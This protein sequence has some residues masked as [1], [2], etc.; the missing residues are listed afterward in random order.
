MPWPDHGT[1]HNDEVSDAA[2]DEA[3]ATHQ[4]IA[5]SRR[6]GETV[7]EP[8]WPILLAVAASIALQ[9][10]LPNRHVLSP[11]FLFPAV[12]VL[13][14]LALLIANPARVGRRSAVRRR[15][16]LALVIVMTVDNLGAVVE[17]VRDILNDAKDDTGTVLLATGGAVWLT[18]VIA[19]SLWYWLLDRGGPAAR[20]DGT[21]SSP[22]FAFSEM[23][24]PDLVAPDWAPQYVDYFY[25]AFTNA[26]A[27]SP[28]DTLPLNSWAKMLMLAQSA[29]SLVVAVMIIA[30][31][32]NILS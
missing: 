9:F 30:R 29:I 1:G 22:S 17:M 15:L 6:S 4:A 27:F 11:T 16:A 10:S 20:R 5:R 28:T 31:A 25:L 26:T 21:A 8:R 18:N 7:A 24:S 2:A 32:V 19:F 13:L 14:L 23:Q 12:E 3:A